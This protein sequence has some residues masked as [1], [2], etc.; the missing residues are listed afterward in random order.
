MC[1]GA[2]SA[3]TSIQHSYYPASSYS[4][5]TT[6]SALPTLLLLPPSI[7]YYPTMDIISNGTAA[8]T[9]LYEYTPSQEAGLAYVGLFGA[10]ALTLFILMFPFRAPFSIPIILGGISTSP[11][12]RSPT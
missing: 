1:L 9:I 2:E 8:G 5:P 4:Y 7:E 11:I 3:T 12:R 10:A 6:R